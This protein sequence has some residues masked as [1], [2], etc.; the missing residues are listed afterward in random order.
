[1]IKVEDLHGVLSMRFGGGG[2]GG[3]IIEVVKAKMLQRAG[4]DGLRAVG[5]VMKMMDDDGSRTLTKQEL[6]TGLAD[7]GLPL[8]IKEVDSLFSFFDRDNSGTVSFDEFLKG[9]R[10]PMS[11]R[12]Q[13]LVNLAFDVVDK[14]GDGSVTVDDLKDVYDV[15]Q[16]PGIIDGSVT[17]EEVLRHFVD[18]WDQGDKDGVVTRD[19]FMEYYADV[20]ASIDG[21]EYFELMIRNAWHIAGGEGEA[22]NSSNRRVLCKFK[23]GV[24]ELVRIMSD[25]GLGDDEKKIMAQLKKEK[26]GEGHGGVVKID[27]KGEG[28]DKKKNKEDEKGEKKGSRK[29]R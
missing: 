14:T 17:K 20:G 15:S 12:R 6:K 9:L 16:H 28:F 18:M 19:E 11:E 26:A 24:E 4:S 22:A 5:R 21:D 23:D 8:N 13:K 25:L 7:W 2:H 1:M 10:G 27:L 29:G 3:S